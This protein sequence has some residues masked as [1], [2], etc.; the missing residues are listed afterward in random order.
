MRAEPHARRPGPPAHPRRRR[1]GPC[2][3]GARRHRVRRLL[4]GSRHPLP[5]LPRPDS[6]PNATELPGIGAA[7]L[8]AGHVRSAVFR[9]HGTASDIRTAV[10]ASDALVHRRTL[11][12]LDR[13]ESEGGHDGGPLPP[14]RPQG[15]LG[16][17]R[18]AAPA[19]QGG[20]RGPRARGHRRG[21]ADR[22]LR[23][24]R[25]GA[26]QETPSTTGARQAARGAPRP[27]GV[28]GRRSWPKAARPP[29]SGCRT[30]ST[31]RRASRR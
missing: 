1:L 5:F 8:P 6:Q 9:P 12:L 13:D 30:A 20:R 23:R 7:H 16:V 17:R 24:A 4:R 21:G 29:G 2:R 10:P 18:L 31:T 27:P 22:G 26:A 15:G 11:P 14:R 3:R 28:P 25:A 19:A